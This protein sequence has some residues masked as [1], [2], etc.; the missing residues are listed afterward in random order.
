MCCLLLLA[1]TEIDVEPLE[2]SFTVLDALEH[3]SVTSSD[4]VGVGVSREHENAS[5]CWTSDPET[6]SSISKELSISRRIF[7]GNSES[8]VPRLYSDWTPFEPTRDRIF[9][10]E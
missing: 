5:Y 10:R 9:V 3:I 4:H 2:M 7:V 6:Q 8:T 1:V